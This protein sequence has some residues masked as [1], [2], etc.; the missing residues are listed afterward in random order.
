L[1]Q[2][3]KLSFPETKGF[4]EI[5]VLYED[6][7][8]LALNKPADLPEVADPAASAQPKPNLIELLHAGV[9]DGKPW[10]Q[11]RG[12][13]YLMPAHRLGPGVSGVLL[14]ARSKPVLAVLANFFGSEKPG[15]S[16]LVLVQGRPQ[17]E[18]FS[19][20]ANVASHPEQ[21]DLVRVDSRQGKRARSLF[22][23]E[24]KFTD[25]TLLRCD[26]LTARPHQIEAHLRYARLPV[27]GDTRYGGRPLRLSSFKPGFRLKPGQTERP[28]LSA[29]PIHCDRIEIPHPVTGAPISISAEWPKDLA[30]AVKYLRKYAAADAPSAGGTSSES[31]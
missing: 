24:E 2:T 28:L 12:L 9:R 13:S 7:D 29:A 20:E 16:F 18:S 8:L 27:V 5:P 15:R 25:W 10:A 21:P 31:P 4:W 30:V 3:I 22:R 26:P 19:I 6:A 23:V 11:A 17:E 14:L 1:S